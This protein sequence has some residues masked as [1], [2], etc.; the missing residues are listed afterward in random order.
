MSLISGAFHKLVFSFHLLLSRLAI[1]VVYTILF[2]SWS[3]SQS[4]TITPVLSCS[5]QYHNGTVEPFHPI[6]FTKPQHERIEEIDSLPALR[7]ELTPYTRSINTYLPACLQVE[8]NGVKAMTSVDEEDVEDTAENKTKQNKTI[9]SEKRKEGNEKRASTEC[10]T[11][12]TCIGL[13][14]IHDF[15]PKPITSPAIV[16][17]KR[18]RPKRR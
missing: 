14:R 1:S 12:C 8:V 3:V 16:D 18:S 6:L 2:L 9:C 10:R 5:T 4:E 7:T 15:S 13:D 11:L 17:N